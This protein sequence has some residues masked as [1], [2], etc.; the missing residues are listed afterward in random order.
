MPKPIFLQW[1][2]ES[3]EQMTLRQRI[4]YLSAGTTILLGLTVIL[5][6]NIAAPFLVTQELGVPDTYVQLPVFDSGGNP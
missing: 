3:Y 6:I 2:K 4:L 5:F 1:I